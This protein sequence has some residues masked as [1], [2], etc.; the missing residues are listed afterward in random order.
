M[1]F[2]DTEELVSTLELLLL[3]VDVFCEALLEGTPIEV[4][5][6]AVLFVR[7]DM[8]RVPVLD[9]LRQVGT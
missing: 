3:S 5:S 8:I 6:K 2:V 1:P 9:V 7:L 4:H